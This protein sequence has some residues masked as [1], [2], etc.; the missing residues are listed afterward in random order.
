M[1]RDVAE[2]GDFAVATIARESPEV[3]RRFISWYLAMGAAEVKV[4]FDNPA[5]P[6][7]AEVSGIDKVTAVPCTRE[8]W[9]E[10]GTTPDYVF[11][12]RQNIA[13]SHAYAHT[14]APWLFI[15]DADELLY[16]RRGELKALLARQ[17]K[18]VRSMIFR[19]AERVGVPGREDETWLRLPMGPK[20]VARVFGAELGAAMARRNGFIGHP[21]GKSILRTGQKGLIIRQHFAQL[22][23]G[24]RIIDK[25]IGWK[26]GAVLLH[27][28]NVSYADWRRKLAVRIHGSSIPRSVGV[29]LQ[30]RLDAGDEAALED[31]YRRIFTI[32]AEMFDELSTY[33][34]LVS[35]H[36]APDHAVATYFP[37]RP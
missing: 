16:F 26:Q 21:N 30:A 36:I 11:V 9:A 29:L 13:M 14:A 8:F 34:V 33:P 18:R 5:D 6:M 27:L 3:M 4:Y 24:V 22:K 15:C 10:R 28:M 7:I 2:P 35:P 20:L 17:R 32:P 1:D 37:G 19:T 12:K 25:I 23:G 31:M